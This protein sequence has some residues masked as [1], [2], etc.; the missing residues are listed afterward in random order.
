MAAS[1]Y[2]PVSEW[3][4]PEAAVAATLVGVRGPGLHGDEAGVFWLGDRA[5]TSVVRAVVLLRGR[6]VVEAPDRW[7]VSPEAYGTVARLARQHGLT[8][9]GT[10][11]IH[12][13]GAPVQLSHVDRRHGVRVP[14][15]L[16]VV[17]GEGGAT[18]DPARWSWNV[19][20]GEDFREFDGDERQRRVTLVSDGIAV[21]CADADGASPW[22]A[23]DE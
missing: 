4:V 18:R 6:G 14:D 19:F 15:I 1:P 17:I 21:W 23:E 12:G 20:D 9:L 11:H 7:L 5:A 10:A 2:P 16:A 13:P 3:R 22:Q 8:L